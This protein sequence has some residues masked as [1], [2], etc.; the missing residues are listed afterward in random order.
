MKK[1]LLRHTQDVLEDKFIDIFIDDNTQLLTEDVPDI[2][3]YLFETYGKVQS[4]IIT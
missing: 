3:T 2:L 4:N 1:A